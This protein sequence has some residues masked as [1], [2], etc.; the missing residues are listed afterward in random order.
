M[1]SNLNQKSRGKKNEN[2]R[3]EDQFE[4]IQK[5]IVE[6]KFYDFII[7]TMFKSQLLHFC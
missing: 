3:R 2:D 7:Q 5:I 1:K 6:W 4:M